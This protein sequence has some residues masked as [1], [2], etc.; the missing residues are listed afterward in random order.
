MKYRIIKYVNENMLCPKNGNTTETETE[1][2]P[3]ANCNKHHILLV[4]YKF[5]L[6]VFFTKTRAVQLALYLV[7]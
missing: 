6:L 4:V 3:W 1:T 7:W 2:T 5:I